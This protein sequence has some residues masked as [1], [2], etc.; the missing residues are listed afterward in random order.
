MEERKWFHSAYDSWRC[1]GKYVSKSDHEMIRYVEF[2]H[3]TDDKITRLVR[4]YENGDIYDGEGLRL[5]SKELVPHG[6]GKW[7]FADDGSI[8]EGEMVA[9]RGEPRFKRIKR[10]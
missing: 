7:T 2:D 9:W 5:P 4:H 8:L 1:S 6:S 10:E 3:Y